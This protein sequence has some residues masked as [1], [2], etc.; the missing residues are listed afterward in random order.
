MEGVWHVW[1]RVKNILSLLA[2]K[3]LLCAN[4]LSHQK[5]KDMVDFWLDSVQKRR[6]F[7]LH[8]NPTQSKNCNRESLHFD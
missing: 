4:D 1:F 2:G 7:F 8:G 3:I 6:T 5:S